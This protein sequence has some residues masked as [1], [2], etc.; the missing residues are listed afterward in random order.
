MVEIQCIQDGRTIGLFQSRN[1]YTQYDFAFICP[2]HVFVVRETFKIDYIKKSNEKKGK[3]DTY[4]RLWGKSLGC[5][6]AFSYKTRCIL[7]RK[8]EWFAGIFIVWCQNLGFQG[9]RKQ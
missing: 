6:I 8:K 2:S 5:I 7:R 1:A 3:M 4:Y 9:R